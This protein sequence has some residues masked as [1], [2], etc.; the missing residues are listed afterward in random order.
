MFEKLGFKIGHSTNKE[1]LTGCTVILCPPNTVGSCFVSGNAPGSRELE[2][3]SPDMTVSE[4]HAIVLTGGSAF[5]LACADGVMRFLEEN[6][7]GYQTPWAKIPIV[8]AAVVYDLNVGNPKI[9]PTAEDGYNACLNASVNFETGLVGAGTGTTV[10]KWAGFE[11]RMN[12]GVGFSI[13][14]IDELIVSAVAVVNSVGDIIDE[15]GKIIAGAKANGKFI[16]E[17][18]KFRFALQRKIQFGTNT[19][20]VCVMT[21]AIL[22]KLETYK[23]SKRA[24]DGIS[25]AIRPAHTSYDGDIIFTLATCKV[26]TEFEILAEL[27]S[28][29]VA[30]AIRDAVRKSNP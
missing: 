27:S 28:Y 14:Q 22:S 19:T 2:L 13:V 3:L 24:D 4:V 10:G 30:E 16:A 15:D 21:N 23:I 18:K 25:R 12:G 8:P 7:I 20:L 11:Y 26:K 17:D 29:V 1:A 9:R 6:G 5:G